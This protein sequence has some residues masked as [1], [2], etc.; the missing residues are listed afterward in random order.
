M[1][2]RLSIADGVARL[3]L[4]RP[5]AANAINL[6]LAI[7]LESAVGELKSDHSVR[8]VILSG[9]GSRFCG[10][11]DVRDFAAQSKEELGAHLGEVTAH[12]HPAVLGLVALDAPVIAA[13][14]G[15]AAGAGFGLALAADLVV[16][17]RSARFGMAYTAIGF[18][19]DA[20]SSWFLPRVVGHRRAL[21]LTLTNRLLTAE[22]ACAWGI[23]TSVVDDDGLETEVTTLAAALAGGAT[24]AYGRARRLLAS[25]WDQP[26][27]AHLDDERRA[28]MQSGATTD[29]YE[30][31][32]AFAEKRPPRFVGA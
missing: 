24:G 7:A 29:G 27:V 15:S 5:E 32:T 26:L 8:A 23:V 6:D 21:E 10:G 17:A 31:V 20:S 4:N 14:Q 18:T 13:V 11:G 2:V 19:P 22:E 30:G 28:L 1:S 3:E 12:F 25:A 9:A 16:A